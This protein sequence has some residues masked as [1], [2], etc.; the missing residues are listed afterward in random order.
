MAENLTDNCNPASYPEF[1]EVPQYLLMFYETKS[2]YF[3]YSIGFVFI[4]DIDN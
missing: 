3:Q 1:L 2:F 4:S